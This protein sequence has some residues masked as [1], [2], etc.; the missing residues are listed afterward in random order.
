[1]L[2]SIQINTIHSIHIY[3]VHSTHIYTVH[4]FTTE[5]NTTI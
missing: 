5:Y 2:Y 3:T 4:I 1:M